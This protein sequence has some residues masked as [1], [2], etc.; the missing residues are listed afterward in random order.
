MIINAYPE[1]FDSTCLQSLRTPQPRR[2][3]VSLHALGSAI[4][5]CLMVI[6]TSASYHRLSLM[7][8]HADQHAVLDYLA[9]AGSFCFA[10]LIAVLC[11]IR[12]K[13]RQ[14]A[15]GLIPVIA[16]LGGAFL[17]TV[18]NLAPMAPLAP[19]LKSVAVLLLATG[20]IL[21]VYCLASLGRSFSI[22]PQAR[23]LVTDG[24]Y[25]LVRHPLYIAE[26]IA[27]VG[28]IMLHF[29]ALSAITGVLILATQMRR[30]MYEERVLSD[31]FPEYAAYAAR[32]PRFIPGLI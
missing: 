17:L 18:V 25:G 5:V 32:V 3:G 28:V 24:P 15:K 7:A 29:N 2:L 9:E 22:L 12:L 11:V 20:N 10:F 4:M 23:K 16:A 27:A 6:I 1:A 21:S 8:A 13:P 30:A 14:Q 31:A 19:G 26:V